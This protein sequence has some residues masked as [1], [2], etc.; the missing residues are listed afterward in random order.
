MTPET[1][2]NKSDY[3]TPEPN[4][5][6]GSDINKLKIYE[7]LSKRKF[8]SALATLVSVL[9]VFYTAHLFSAAGHSFAFIVVMFIVLMGIPV[10]FLLAIVVIILGYRW[11][12]DQGRLNEVL[13]PSQDK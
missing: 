4:N 13:D 2:V 6:V 10:I 3:I 11:A 5:L 7:D 12:R 8:F 9:L 1:E